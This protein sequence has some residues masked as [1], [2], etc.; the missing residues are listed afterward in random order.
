MIYTK[1][2]IEKFQ[3]TIK[4][5]KM[6]DECGAVLCGFSGGADSAVLLHL[7]RAFCAENKIRLAAVHVNHM[8][9]GDAAVRDQQHC[10]CFCQKYHIELF[11]KRVNIPQIAEAENM[12]I[13]ETARLQRYKIFG[14]IC[15]NEGF[16]KIAA[17]HHAGDNFETVLFHLLRGTGIRGL[18]G[19]PPVRGNIV[20]P[21]IECS[22]KEIIGFCSENE[23]NY[24]SDDSNQDTSYTR[25]F[26]REKI[27]PLTYRVNAGAEENVTRMCSQLRRDSDFL[28]TIAANSIFFDDNDAMLTR[29]I[30]NGYFAFSGG[31][32]LNSVHI[33]D[34]LRLLRKGK[35]H[36]T[37]SLPAKIAIRKTREGFIFENENRI[38][39][40]PFSIPMKTGK[41]DLGKAGFLFVCDHFS[42]IKEMKNIYKLF[43]YKSLYSDKIKGGAIIRSRQNGDFLQSGGMKRSVKKLLCEKKIE[44]RLRWNLPFVCDEEGILWIPGVAVRDG[45]EAAER[46]ESEAGIL[47]I[48]YS[49]QHE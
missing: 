37:V 43:I 23:L 27:I 29:R 17:A 31:R 21:L 39:R 15:V 48:G 26:I 5:Y 30:Q 45:A 13:E 4:K 24:V 14:E 2:I 42:K 47:Y 7:L 49:A 38:P 40:E 44:P 34:A 32:Q 28:D 46:D 35:L 19:I 41:N 11:V 8:I 20:R 25:N 9:R 3:D 16:S 33:E 22:K 36:G 12:G 18:C 6:F 10:V 1:A